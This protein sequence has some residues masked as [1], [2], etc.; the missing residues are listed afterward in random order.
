M[1]KKLILLLA[2]LCSLCLFLLPVG[3]DFGDFGGGDDYDFD[4]DFGGGNDFDFDFGNN[5]DYNFG[6]DNNNYGYDNDD[7]DYDYHY[8][9]NDDDD[10]YN[11]AY[12]TNDYDDVHLTP[13]EAVFGFFC[14][15]GP[16]AAI[17]VLAFLL[18]SLKKNKSF[19]SADTSHTV[20]GTPIATDPSTLL[21][22]AQYLESDPAFDESALCDKL[23]NLYVQ[24]Q[25]GWMAHDISPL[26]PYFTDAL[27]TRFERQLAQKTQ[28]GQTNYVERIAVLDT[29]LLGF[30]RDSANDY[31]ILRLRSRIVDY[32]LDDKTGRLVSG[33]RNKE[34]FMTYEYELTRSRGHLTTP[35]TGLTAITCPHCGAP[36]DINMSARCEY[37]D[38]VITLDK[39][40]WVISSIKGISQKS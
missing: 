40:D 32:T 28:A 11:Y 1:K 36:L 7:D 3:A 22:L 21:S 20:R 14:C 24:M 5:N 39:H 13:G 33:D 9:G 18:P 38:S 6:N 34:L 29:K 31:A 35:D 2:L 19:S 27:F 30:K 17:F 16:I 25:N 4:F 12:N 26:R 23:A 8:D 37:C 15:I 10:D